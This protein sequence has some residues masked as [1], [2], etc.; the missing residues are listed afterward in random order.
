[1]V[2]HW[3]LQLAVGDSEHGQIDGGHK[4]KPPQSGRLIEGVD[5]L[6]ITR[7]QTGRDTRL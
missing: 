3:Q 5:N 2:M 6:P 4:K 7:H 1:M